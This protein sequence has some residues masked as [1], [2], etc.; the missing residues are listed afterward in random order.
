VAVLYRVVPIAVWHNKAS[1]GA[2]LLSVCVAAVVIVLPVVLG[3]GRIPEE[4][5]DER[6]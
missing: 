6:P 2:L 3:T 5:A 1:F 4:Q